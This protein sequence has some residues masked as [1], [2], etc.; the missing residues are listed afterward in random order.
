MKQ[1]FYRDN[2]ILNIVF[3]DIQTYHMKMNTSVHI[4]VFQQVYSKN[5]NKEVD[6]THTMNNLT[7][8]KRFTN[9]IEAP[10]ICKGNFINV[11]KWHT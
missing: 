1:T 3:L 6:L 11:V 8:K 4:E 5:H 7:R 10:Y 9:S 2:L